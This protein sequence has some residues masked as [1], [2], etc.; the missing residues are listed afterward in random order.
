MRREAIGYWGK[1]ESTRTKE[2]KGFLPS[3][4]IGGVW[5]G[6][7]IYRY[8]RGNDV[9][10]DLK[11]N[12]AP[13]IA[14][15]ELSIPSGMDVLVLNSGI[16][17]LGLALARVNPQA[18]FWLNDDNVTSMRVIDRNIEVNAD[19]P[20]E[21]LVN[22]SCITADKIQQRLKEG[23]KFDIIVL[24]P[25]NNQGLD[26]IRA[27]VEDVSLLLK[28]GGILYFIT[29]KKQGEI[30]HKKILEEVF[31]SESVRKLFVGRGGY[32]I[33]S[34]TN[35]EER[36]RRIGPRPQQEVLVKIGNREVSYLTEPGLFSHKGLD[37]GTK[38][39]LETILQEEILRSNPTR[40]MDLGCGW[41][42]IG[43]TMALHY[44]DSQVVLVDNSER[45]VLAAIRNIQKLRITNTKVVLTGDLLRDVS[46][47]FDLI[48]SNPPFHL[49]SHQLLDLFK[50][51]RLKLKPN[52]VFVIVVERTFLQKFKDILTEAF[53][54]YSSLSSMNYQ[55]TEY[56]ILKARK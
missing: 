37:N 51:A 6:I 50:N 53:G 33:Y 39:L 29:H 54:N 16:G 14:V 49:D 23:R 17:V 7:T 18:N 5:P 31:G 34:A 19:H 25:L 45:A 1:Y 36:E 8:P 41:G 9:L 28:E 24:Q 44:P 38:F 40:I 2:R 56:Y 52:G 22:A 42:V 35:I 55:G 32:R 48:L 26:I 47:K 43:C 10:T 12:L 20:E 3:L 30:R 11:R 27:Q 15:R 46:G 13:E 4:I 21:P